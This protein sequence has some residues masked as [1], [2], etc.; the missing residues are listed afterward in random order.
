MAKEATRGTDFHFYSVGIVVEDK[1][2]EQDY[3]VVAPME[4]L[5]KSEGL[6]KDI[7]M[8][9][10]GSLPNLK[11][12]S[13]TLDVTLRATIT[14]KWLPLGHSNRETAPDVYKNETV[15]LFRFGDEDKY[16][17]T[18]TMREPELR[19][20]EHVY[21]MYSNRPEP[22]VAYDEETSY[23]ELWSTMDKL[24]HRHTSDNDG[25]PFRYDDVLNT[26]EGTWLFTDSI[27]NL[28]YLESE[29][30]RWTLRN[31]S[32]AHVILDGDNIR[33]HAPDQVHID[34]DDNILE[35]APIIVLRATDYICEHAPN[36]WLRG[37]VTIGDGECGVGDF[38]LSYHDYPFVHISRRLEHARIGNAWESYTHYDQQDMISITKGTIQ[39]ETPAKS[40]K[41]ADSIT[42]ETTQR[43]VVATESIQETTTVKT[44]QASDSVNTIATEA[45]NEET[46][47][48]SLNASESIVE[49]TETR[50]LK[51]KT[52]L[53]ET[54]DE[55]NILSEKYLKQHA[56]Y[57]QEFIYDH[58]NINGTGDNGIFFV[59]NDANGVEE[60]RFNIFD[61]SGS[62]SAASQAADE[63]A[64]ASE[65]NAQALQ[66]LSDSTV[67]LTQK[68]EVDHETRIVALE[69]AV[70]DLLLRVTELEQK[71]L[72]HENRIVVL[73]NL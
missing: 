34:A 41:A 33:I 51:A 70:Q 3:I 35:T 28:L 61:L 54:E 6:L 59:K 27:Q 24:I 32:D 57:R 58:D 9:Y 18:T 65:Q 23:W 67:S 69:Q 12:S 63:A 29:I 39:E 16:F 15:F 71:V 52:S 46:K 37:S 25:E 4:D 7:K 68:V 30:H 72:D 17:W 13:K 31:A 26:K 20:L 1:V 8:E 45:I 19:R 60:E 48:F 38:D 55:Y 44:V 21:Y 14:A 10:K 62:V 64:E 50:S 66:N 56:K 43:S 2:R 47:A 5:P 73:E 40:T 11:G 49:E 36:I 42:E 53:V 22:L